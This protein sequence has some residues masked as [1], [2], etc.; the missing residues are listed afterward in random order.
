M[1]YFSAPIGILKAEL[2]KRAVFFLRRAVCVLKETQGERRS[3]RSL[4]HTNL[5]FACST[6]ARP[7]AGQR[8]ETGNLNQTGYVIIADKCVQD[9]S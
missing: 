5:R 1:T 4:R 9:L 6:S 2:I 8:Y 7:M 3:G